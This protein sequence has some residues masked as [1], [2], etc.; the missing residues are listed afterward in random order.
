MKFGPTARPPFIMFCKPL[1]K[2]QIPAGAS[3]VDRQQP[4]TLSAVSVAGNFILSCLVMQQIIIQESRNIEQQL[5]RR[6]ATVTR[7]TKLVSCPTPSP[8]STFMMTPAFSSSAIL[9]RGDLPLCHLHRSNTPI[10][11]I[12]RLQAPADLLLSAVCTC[13]VL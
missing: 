12:A 7:K 5:K 1:P 9:L 8:F 11:L 6:S 13:S 3:H 10:C 4:I 2:C